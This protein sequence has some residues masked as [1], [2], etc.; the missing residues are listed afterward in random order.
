M[1]FKTFATKK[2]I[3]ITIAT[4]ALVCTSMALP[5][6]RNRESQ[7]ITPDNAT[8]ASADHTIFKI[9]LICKPFINITVARVRAT[10]VLRNSFARRVNYFS[11]STC[12]MLKHS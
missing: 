4:V 5:H 7:N 8:A 2:I 1:S 9:F 10:F 12:Y 11:P 6:T 3:P